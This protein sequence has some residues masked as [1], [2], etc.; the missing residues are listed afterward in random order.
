M[1]IRRA[2]VAAL[3]PLLLAACE[4]EF[5]QDWTATPDT[6]ELFSLTRPELIGRASAFD[7][8]PPGVPIAVENPAAT[9]NWDIA[10]VDN[11]GTLAFLP[12]SGFTGLSSR[13]AIAEITVST[14]LEQLEEAPR[15]T[16]DFK[17]TA[18]P[19]RVGRIYVVR[20]R[21]A[22]CGFGSFGVRYAKL[23]ALSVS[24]TAG[25][26]RFRTIVNPYCN[27]RALIPPD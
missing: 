8:V 3:F 2:A 12:A 6:I 17:Y 1:R 15:D 13:A 4:D 20:T 14:T 21:R 23:E 10:I 9:G 16:A 22:D 18:V 19:V 25:S 26:V 27:N 7:F 5:R 24:P 11:G